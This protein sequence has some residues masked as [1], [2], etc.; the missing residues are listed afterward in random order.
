[1]NTVTINLINGD[2]LSVGFKTKVY[3]WTSDNATKDSEFYAT[4]VCD[5]SNFDG[6]ILGTSDP[7]AGLQGLL[8]IADWFALDPSGPIYRT[9]AILSIN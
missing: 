8:G 5:E 4:M 6:N 2:S 7:R 1:M 9:S 3:A